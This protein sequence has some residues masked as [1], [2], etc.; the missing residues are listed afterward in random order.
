MN[1]RE[2]RVTEQD[3]HA[4]VDDQ[5]D[6]ARRAEI[7]AYLQMTPAEAAKVRDYQRIN[8]ALQTLHQDVLTAAIPRRLRRQ[9]KLIRR[10]T[11]L[12]AAAVAGWLLCG[13]VIGWWLRAQWPMPLPPFS[14]A[15]VQEALQAHAVYLPEVRH[16][17]EVPA[18]QEKHLVAWLS[19]RLA[20]SIQAPK[21]AA[22]GFELLGGRLLPAG[23]GP[24]AQFMYQNA[25]G[26]RLTLFVRKDVK[27]SPDTA[28]QFVEKNHL[29]AFYW[30]DQ[31]LGYALIG[32]VERDIL[33]QLAASVYQQLAY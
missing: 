22:A 12:S 5:L 2:A 9:G 18:E 27:G 24:A 1:D 25:Q 3:L 29:N 14:D 8:Q 32:D 16:P 26:Q 28:F 33:T 11:W 6:H 4:Y 31:D 13:G 17:V 15:L 19:K 10:R 21:L 30:I 20:A 23:D 7:E